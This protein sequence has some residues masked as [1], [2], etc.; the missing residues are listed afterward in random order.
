MIL[1]YMLNKIATLQFWWVDK[2]LK[3]DRDFRYSLDDAL[4]EDAFTIEIISGKFAGVKIRYGQIKVREDSNGNAFIDVESTVVANPK[5]VNVKCKKFDRLC[6]NI[7]R[8]ILLESIKVA[9]NETRDVDFV[10]F[11]EERGVREED[12]PLYQTRVPARKSRK[13]NVSGD[14]GV[15]SKV[16]R[17]AKRRS[18]KD[19]TEG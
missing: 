8:L 7:V 1:A 10:E 15:H 16:Q 13:S 12:D 2:T 11:D 18:R 9:A 5:S 6:S 19:R 3:L 14:S 4:E 17:P